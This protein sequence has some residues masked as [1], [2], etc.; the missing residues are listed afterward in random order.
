M[1]KFIL[2]GL[3]A[4][5]VLYLIV[6]AFQP[7]DFRVSRSATITAPPETIFGQIN[8]LH[9]WN[10]WSP[11]AKLDPNMKNTFSG[12]PEG[13]GARPSVGR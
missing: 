8:N 1:L 9:H 11:F 10:Q 12:P 13:V 5:V 7:A 2:I 3:A 4:I 6:A